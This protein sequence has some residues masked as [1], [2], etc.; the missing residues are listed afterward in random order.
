MNVG[1][2]RRGRGTAG[3]IA[4]ACAA[5]APGQC[6]SSWSE[7]FGV[8]GYGMN[9]AVEA[10]AVFDDDGVG[11]NPP[12]LYAGGW[13]ASAGGS[14]AAHVARWTGSG[15][16]AL[17]SGTTGTYVQ[18]LAVHGGVLYAGGLF[19]NAGGV[20]AINVARWDGSAWSAC[21]LGLSD[22]VY[23]LASHD[24]GTGPALYAGGEFVWTGGTMLAGKVARWNG[25]S[26]SSVGAG[27]NQTAHV[28]AVH[29]DGTGPALYCGGFFAVAGNF[30]AK[31]NGFNWSPL[32]IGMNSTVYALASFDEDGPGPNH[33]RLYAGG[34]FDNAGGVTVNRVARWNGASWSGLNGG[35][36]GVSS[37]FVYAL[38]VF[39]D[40]GGPALYV[41]GDFNVA[42]GVAAK[43]IARWDGSAFTALGAGLGGSFPWTFALADFDDGTGPALYV[44]GT[45]ETTGGVP[46]R[47]IGR[48]GCTPCYPDCNNSGTLTVADFGCF[49]GKYVLSDLYADCNAS[50]T[51]TVAD[52]GC[53]QGKYVLG[54]P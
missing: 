18:A 14:G 45:F 8:P 43:G 47:N 33:A 42:G 4:L 5:G 35:I 13:F 29:D 37:P 40:G 1:L 48:W 38:H 34:Y 39:D 10:L 15:W 54:C 31:W 16:A 7:G 6:P 2:G 24:D 25:A 46:A 12:A 53:Y 19:D 36:G 52:F 32:G 28:L 21:G 9:D 23:A 27:I 3:C 11:P 51:L 41:G 22:R 44:G 17:G 26:W 30:I 50:G 49:Q 20:A